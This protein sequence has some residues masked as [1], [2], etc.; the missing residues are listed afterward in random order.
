MD[1]TLLERMDNHMVLSILN[2]KLRL[3]CDSLSALIS[4]YELDSGQLMARMSQIGY[5]YD[6]NSNQ[7]KPGA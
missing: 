7:F 6:P 3:E 4:R 1:R 5:R 2:E